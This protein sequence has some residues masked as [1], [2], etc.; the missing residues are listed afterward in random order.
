MTEP[1][2]SPDQTDDL[3]PERLVEIERIKRLKYA[4]LRLL[5]QKRWTDL[6]SL[7]TPDATASYGGGRHTHTGADAIVDWIAEAMGDPGVHSAHR[8]TQPE[9]TFTS[10]TDADGTWA[11]VDWV[12]DTRFEVTVEG[13]A[14]YE[15]RYRKVDGQWRIAHT[16]YKRT[17]E[18]I[19]PR[20]SIEG[21]RLTASWWS[22]DGV[23]SL[24]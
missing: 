18:E 17:F 15:D 6:R 11:M 12:I 8:C 5:D 14:F 16:G 9:I 13:A 23:S 24:G 4:Y 19:F 3:T 22:T 10:D 21:L 7:F 1:A 20:G 2:S